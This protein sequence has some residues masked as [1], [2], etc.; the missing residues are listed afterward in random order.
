MVRVFDREGNWIDGSIQDDPQDAI[1]SV[2]R[3][4]VDSSNGESHGK[5]PQVVGDGEEDLAGFHALRA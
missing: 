1:L 4:G 3:N 2:S 5:D